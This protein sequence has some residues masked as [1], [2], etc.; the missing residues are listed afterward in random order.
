MALTACSSL[1]EAD[2]RTKG[3]IMGRQPMAF[4]WL[5]GNDELSL[6]A[7]RF[8]ANFRI[9]EAQS[10]SSPMGGVQERRAKNNLALPHRGR[11]AWC[12]ASLRRTSGGRTRR[13]CRRGSRAWS[14]TA[15]NLRGR[16]RGRRAGRRRSLRRRACE[17]LG[18][19][20]AC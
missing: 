20:R 13:T 5:S 4:S 1:A 10:G 14:G 15:R 8:S 18:G 19:R 11:W 3:I 2:S 16:R 9:C 6:R 12:P 17:Q 7:E